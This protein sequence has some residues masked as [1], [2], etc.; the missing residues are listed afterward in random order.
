MIFILLFLFSLDV[1]GIA[2]D[3]FDAETEEIA[4][5]TVNGSEKA[6]VA[7]PVLSR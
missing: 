6:S 1:R 3:D 4:H 5:V 7:Q 2:G